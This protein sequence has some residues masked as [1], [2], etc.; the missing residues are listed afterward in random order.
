MAIDRRKTIEMD[1]QSMVALSLSKNLNEYDGMSGERKTLPVDQ[2]LF[3]LTGNDD[4]LVPSSLYAFSDLSRYDTQLVKEHWLDIPV[5]RRRWVVQQLVELAEDEIDLH[6]GRILRI[7]LS[8]EDEY[9]RE[10]AVVGLWED[11]S[12]D[13]GNEYL[14][15]LRKDDSPNVRAAIADALGNYILAGEL[16]EIDAS[17]ATRAE[18]SLLNIIHDE[19]EPTGIR[20][21]ALASVAYSGETGVRQLIEDG[22]Y[23]PDEEMRISALKAMG[24][25]ADIR[26][27]NLVRAELQNPSPLMRAEAA[28]ACGELGARN[29]A[30]A[31]LFLLQDDAP[32]VRRAAIFAL[33]RIGGKDA[34]EALQIIVQEGDDD[35]ERHAAESALDDLAFYADPDGVSLFDESVLLDEDDDASDD[36]EKDP[37]DDWIGFDEDDLGLYEE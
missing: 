4:S 23:S 27:R 12:S 18:D 31:L 37:W 1:E 21:K 14:R 35:D 8:D 10:S 34:T 11:L 33:G 5:E 9:I 25:S 16:D 7:A 26:W 30:T 17:L 24:R 19:D 3:R 32:V 13:L 2:L 29:A 15:M 36:W 28:F 6:L 20:S 22:Y